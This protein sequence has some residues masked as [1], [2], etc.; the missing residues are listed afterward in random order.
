MDYD[1]L[2]HNIAVATELL[3]KYGQATSWNQNERAIKDDMNTIIEVMNSTEKVNIEN[4]REKINLCESGYG[5]WR[6]WCGKIYCKCPDV[7]KRSIIILDKV[8][9]S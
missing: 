7:E 4:V 3:E 8:N 6:N 5:H 1:I 9:K 2:K